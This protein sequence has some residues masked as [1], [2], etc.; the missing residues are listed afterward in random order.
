MTDIAAHRW[1][2]LLRPDS[3]RTSIDV[4]VYKQICQ[5]PPARLRYMSYGACCDVEG[6]MP[7]PELAA[8]ADGDSVAVSTEFA[9][10]CNT[11]SYLVLGAV[12]TALMDRG[13]V[14]SPS[15]QGR[16]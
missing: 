12:R 13:R 11:G 6:A 9:V 5:H 16:W 4:N 1:R 10:A 14:C 3:R 15:R 2:V 8:T 7:L